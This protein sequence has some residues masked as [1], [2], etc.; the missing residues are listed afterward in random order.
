MDKGNLTL[1]LVDDHELVRLGLKALLQQDLSYRVVAEARDADEA[2][3]KALRYRPDV[4]IMEI[5]L[6][7]SSGIDATRSIKAALPHVTVLMLTSSTE[8]AQLQAAWEEGAS[9]YLL[10]QQEADAI[11]RALEAV[12]CG[13]ASLDPKQ[14]ARQFAELGRVERVAEDEQLAQ[15][16]EQE[17]HVLGL[18]GLGLTNSQIAARLHLAQGT[19]CNYTSMMLQKL[20]LASRVQAAYA[21]RHHVSAYLPE[22][23]R[24]LLPNHQG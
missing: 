4:V 1:L 19:V 18:L 23:R 15:Q 8:E 21:V 5:Q 17:L 2:L 6:D 16:T 24:E 14:L 11:L 20:G 13:T 9:S 10:K 3:A 22:P 12:R 7:G